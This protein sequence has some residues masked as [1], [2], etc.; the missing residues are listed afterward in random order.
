MR[1][2]LQTLLNAF[3]INQQIKEMRETKIGGSED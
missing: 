1:L 2:G 3:E